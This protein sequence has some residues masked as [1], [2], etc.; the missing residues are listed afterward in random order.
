MI[1]GDWRAGWWALAIAALVVGVVPSAYFLRRRLEDLGM[2]P[3]GDPSP[4]LLAAQEAESPREEDFTLHEAVRTRAYWLMGI[5]IGL[6]MMTAGSINFHQ[7]PYLRDQGLGGPEAA[8]IVTVFSIVGAF[9][10]CWA[11][12]SRTALSRGGR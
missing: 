6:L 7:I 4:V 12:S 3:D 1:A 2:R 9:V 10:D 11:D 5:A 8:V